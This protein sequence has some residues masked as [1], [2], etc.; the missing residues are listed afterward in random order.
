MNSRVQGLAKSQ[1][2]K[3]AEKRKEERI[4]H[5]FSKPLE[6]IFATFRKTT[7]YE[8]RYN[9]QPQLLSDS[10]FREWVALL[11]KPMPLGGILVGIVEYCTVQVLAMS[12]RF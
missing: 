3:R 7:Q 4:R 6:S 10:W 12:K 8:C 5:P 9:T 2:K 1:L 11:D